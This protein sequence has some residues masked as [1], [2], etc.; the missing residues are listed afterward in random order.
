MRAF[1]TGSLP[2]SLA[3]MPA[4]TARAGMEDCA[5]DEVELSRESTVPAETG[6]HNRPTGRTF[7]LSSAGAVGS[8]SNRCREGRSRSLRPSHS[9]LTWVVDPD[10][11]NCR[12][13]LVKSV[14]SAT[15]A[16]AVWLK[17]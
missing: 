15:Y 7:I 13:E 12:L 6:S 9:N 4:T 16:S 3:T 2:G 17:Y 10:Q 5:A 1:F 11:K 8:A 14:E